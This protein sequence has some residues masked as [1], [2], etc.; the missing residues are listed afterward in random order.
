MSPPRGS[1]N[2]ELVNRASTMTRR[3]K[4][5]AKT[6]CSIANEIR[7]SDLKSLTS[8]SKQEACANDPAFARAIGD[9]GFAGVY[10]NH[11]K[12]LFGI[13]TA[14]QKAVRDE[15]RGPQ[16]KTNIERKQ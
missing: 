16:S 14:P 4:T 9:V 3:A 7:K 15:Y 5:I 2:G 11:K 10:I 13:K 12:H 6:Q 8:A 1:R